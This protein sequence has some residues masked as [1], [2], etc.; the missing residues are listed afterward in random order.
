M[1]MFMVMCFGSGMASLSSA[2]EIV[3]YTLFEKDVGIG[4]DIIADKTESRSRL[5]CATICTSHA[6]CVT[7]SYVNNKCTLSSK[8]IDGWKQ[9]TKYPSPGE[10]LYSGK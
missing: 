9:F 8:Q 3:G 1:V 2:R 6:Q 5:H 10:H 7:Y 4:D